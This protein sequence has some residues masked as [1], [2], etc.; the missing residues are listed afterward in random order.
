MWHCGYKL[1]V[2]VVFVLSSPPPLLNLFYPFPSNLHDTRSSVP[3]SNEK[4]IK[5]ESHSHIPHNRR[6]RVACKAQGQESGLAYSQLFIR[7]GELG[8]GKNERVQEIKRRGNRNMVESMSSKF[9]RRKDVRISSD[10]LDLESEIG[11]REK[12]VTRQRE[13]VRK[14]KKRVPKS[15]GHGNMEEI[16]E[17][18]ELENSRIEPNSLQVLGRP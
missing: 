1:A 16:A 8:K 14:R 13:W 5:T 9:L 15:S 12:E 10:G 17:E 3:V 2:V 4:P 18:D 7:E 11:K 6:P